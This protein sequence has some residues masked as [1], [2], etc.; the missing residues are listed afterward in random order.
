MT[1][2]STRLAWRVTEPLHAMIYFA[3]EGFRRFADLGLSAMEGYFAA[4]GGVFGVTG[5]GPVIATFYNFNPALVRSA[6]PAA[7]ER[8]TPAAALDAQLSAADEA[9]RR[10]LGAVDTPEI[11]EAAGLAR[12]AAES[13][14]AFP[15]GRPLFAAHAALPWPAEP[16]LQL[17]RAQGVLREFRGDGHVSAL[18]QAGVTGVEANVLQVAAGRSPREF[19]Q[20]TRGWSDDEWGAAT[21]ALRTRG[22]VSDEGLTDAGKAQV[23]EL[24]AITDRLAE[25]GWAVLGEEGRLRLAELTRPLSRTIVKAGLLDPMNLVKAA[26]KPAGP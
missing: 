26:Q 19:L 2:S 23:E 22:W 20:V 8:T 3:P 17:F 16:H 24:E 13:A 9:L 1:E 18:L 10:G 6:L 7:W 12:R 15:Q 11:V 4:R 25:P 21:D 14:A 5:P